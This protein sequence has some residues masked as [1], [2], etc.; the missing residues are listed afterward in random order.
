MGDELRNN[1][2]DLRS[3]RLSEKEQKEFL[4]MFHQA[5]LEYDLKKELYQEL[6]NIQ[7]V[8]A[9]DNEIQTRFDRMWNRI[10]SVKKQVPKRTLNLSYAYWAAAILMLGFILGNLVHLVRESVTEMAYYTAIA[11]KGSVSETILPDGTIIFLNAGS[12]IKYASNMD[13]KSREVY[14]KGEAWFDVEKSKEIPFIVHTSYYDVRVMGTEFNVRAYIEDAE[15]ITTLEKGSIE[16]TSTNDFKIEKNVTLNPGEQLV[17]N[18]QKNSLFVSQVNPGIYSSWKD[19]KLIFINMS[20][21]E[22]IILLERKYGVEIAVKDS[23]ILKFHYDGTIRNETIME[24]LNILQ[25][26]LP[27]N[28]YIENQKVVIM[29]K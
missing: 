3:G 29:K 14:L 26:T 27:I 4:A 13:I 23:D 24:V 10:E 21:K 9:D 28:Y 18:K 7:E 19:N 15:V 5:G 20:L 1:F 6:E 17:Y 8:I 2:E 22:L 12:E 16:V 25:K 11:P